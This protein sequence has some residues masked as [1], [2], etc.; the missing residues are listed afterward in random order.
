M[1]RENRNSLVQI[2]L[3]TGRKNQ[4]RV[5]FMEIGH[6]VLGDLKYGKEK[7]KRLML[8]ATRLDIRDPLTSKILSFEIKVP[9]E[10]LRNL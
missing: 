2:L 3:E 9:R 6:P 10:F 5:Q 8:A 1:I 7:S 4:I